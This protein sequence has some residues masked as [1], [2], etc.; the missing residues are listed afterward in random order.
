MVSIVRCPGC[1]KATVAV[2]G[3]NRAQLSCSHCGRSLDDA[4]KLAHSD[5][6]ALEVRVRE[7]LHGTHGPAKPR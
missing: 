1:G 5:P 4:E 2:A 6:D 7:Q 3:P